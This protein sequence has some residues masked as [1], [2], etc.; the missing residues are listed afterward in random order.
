MDLKDIVGLNRKGVARALPSFCTANDYVLDDLIGFAAAKDLPVLIE[1]TCN[2]V[3]QFGGYTGMTPRDYAAKIDQK[4]N[5]AGLRQDQLVLGG[6][7][8]GPNPW[9]SLPADQA[10]KH[11]RTLVRDYVEAGFTKIHLDTS[12]ACG[13]ELTPSF[14]C[15]ADRSAELCAVAERFA[16][17]A[18]RLSYVIGTEVPVPGGES[19]DMSGIQPTTPDKLA[20]TIETHI[21]A[22]DARGVP[23]GIARAIAVVVQPGVDFSHIGLFHYDRQK[24]SGLTRGI[25][26]YDGLGFEA[27]STD[28]QTTVNLAALVADHAVVLK[29][30]PEITFRFREAIMA[31][32]HIEAVLGLSDPGNAIDAV[33]KAMD[34]APG[35]WDGYYHGSE[36]DLRL[37]KL[38]S[39]SDRIRYYWDHPDVARAVAKLIDNV[40]RAGIPAPLATQYGIDFPI[41]AD[42]ISA[43]EI[44]TTRV[45]TTARRYYR[46]GGWLKD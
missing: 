43:R 32:D 8:L 27:H 6:D 31:L 40:T 7:H 36:P 34:D 16:P 2:Q 28:Y 33:L 30:G 39:Y 11:A 41:A 35:D 14:E 45:T 12:M 42:T 1:A 24:A 37:L 44:I 29:V 26:Q 25:G 9:R 10:M 5:A 23:Q 3:N 13:G 38:F 22:F 18:D 20:K 15:V 17:D 19:D 46:A 4:A 21:A